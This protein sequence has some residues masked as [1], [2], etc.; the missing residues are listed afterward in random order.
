MHWKSIEIAKTQIPFN[1]HFVNWR[2]K[3]NW[4]QHNRYADEMCLS[5][6][7]LRSHCMD[8]FPI[9]LILYFWNDSA[10]GKGYF[11]WLTMILGNRTEN[12]FILGWKLT[13][14]VNACVR[15]PFFL[16]V[17]WIFFV[18][19]FKLKIPQSTHSN[20]IQIGYAFERLVWIENRFQKFNDSAI[21]AKMFAKL[22][23][24]VVKDW[25]K[26]TVC[27]I[28]YLDWRIV[29]GNIFKTFYMAQFQ[30]SPPL[31]FLSSGVLVILLLW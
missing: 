30:L 24:M 26:E 6:Y 20:T 3:E 23:W 25:T 4:Q 29:L 12:R 18:I 16:L 27:G 11:G 19:Q 21:R 8:T 13:K 31:R 14:N 28:P 15:S 2:E 9:D 22:E 7:G 5:W 17:L 1:F 10:N